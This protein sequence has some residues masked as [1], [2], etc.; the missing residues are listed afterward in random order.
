MQER[1]IAFELITIGHLLKRERDRANEAIKERILGPDHKISCDD[2]GI[3]KY[4]ADN[5]DREIYQK[6]IEQVFSLTAPSVSNKLRGLQ[7]KGFI[8]RVYSAKDTRLK[9]VILTDYGREVDK[10]MRHEM[11]KFEIQLQRLLSDHDIDLLMKSI[12]TLKHFFND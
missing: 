9:Q 3:M 5:L 11:E 2:L 1:K 12:D 7:K 10:K 6:E 4:I 8:D